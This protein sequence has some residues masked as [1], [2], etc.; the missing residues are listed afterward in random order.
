MFWERCFGP[1]PI[2]RF[3]AQGGVEEASVGGSTTHVIAPPAMTRDDA[4]ARLAL[5]DVA[6]L[7]RRAGDGGGDGDCSGGG[8]RLHFVSPKWLSDCLAQGARLPEGPYHTPLHAGLAEQLARGLLPEV[9]QSPKAATATTAAAPPTSLAADA[10]AAA[11]AGAAQQD[12]ATP[13]ALEDVPL[14]VRR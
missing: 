1:F 14:A 12:G 5:S 2:A 7:L 11:A 10:D 4:A 13:L 3:K 6:Q 9:E 8:P